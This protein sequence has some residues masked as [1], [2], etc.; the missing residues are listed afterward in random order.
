MKENSKNRNKCHFW[1]KNYEDIIVPVKD[2]YD[3][4]GK[5]RGSGHKV[6]NLNH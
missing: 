1:C 2:H 5:Y 4:T 6:C 3:V